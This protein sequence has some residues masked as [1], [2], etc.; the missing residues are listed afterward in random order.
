MGLY[1]KFNSSRDYT[2]SHDYVRK[3][4]VEDLLR[5]SIQEYLHQ[6]Y[7]TTGAS[8]AWVNH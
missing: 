2:V 3:E 1:E 5:V 8:N 4:T 6:V 7:L